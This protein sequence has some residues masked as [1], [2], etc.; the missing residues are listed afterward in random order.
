LH[1]SYLWNSLRYMVKSYKEGTD[2]RQ[3]K[4]LNS[5]PNEAFLSQL[6]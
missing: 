6:F 3:I 5:L 2:P 4:N 1:R